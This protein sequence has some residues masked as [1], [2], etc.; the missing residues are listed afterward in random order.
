MQNA[1]LDTIKH[2]F[3]KISKV[4][5]FTLFFSES[6]VCLGLLVRNKQNR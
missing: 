4:L 2:C 3:R 1:A 6:G 5:Y